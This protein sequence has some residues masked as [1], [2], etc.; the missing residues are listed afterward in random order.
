M[1]NAKTVLVVEDDDDLRELFAA[2]LARYGYS[3]AE[4]V[5]GQDALDFLKTQP[6]PCLVLLDM[7]M[8]V[9]DG[10]QFLAALHQEHTFD[11]MPVVVVSATAPN[12]SGARRVVRKPVSPEQIAAIAHEFC[13]C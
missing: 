13:P 2:C 10:A 5:N 4:A 12:V 11:S 9:M 8:P 6:R 3:V 1:V 7:R